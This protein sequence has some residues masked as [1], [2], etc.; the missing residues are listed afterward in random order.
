MDEITIK[1]ETY[2]MLMEGKFNFIILRN[3]ILNS[4]AKYSISDNIYLENTFLDVFKAICPYDFD[5]KVRELKGSE[6]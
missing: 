6:D 3:A 2:N 5:R 1:I 4:M